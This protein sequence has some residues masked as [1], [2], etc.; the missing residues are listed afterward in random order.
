MEPRAGAGRV[1]EGQGQRWVRV[2]PPGQGG[3]PVAPASAL[4][5]WPSL[6][7]DKDDSGDDHT[8]VPMR[9]AGQ[10]RA[11]L[12]LCIL[13]LCPLIICNA[14]MNRIA[15]PISQMTKLKHKGVK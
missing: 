5:L 10:T 2:R 7:H 6:T 9:V 13:P 4:L 14:G 3:T 8:R 11:A 15:F 12:G 1:P